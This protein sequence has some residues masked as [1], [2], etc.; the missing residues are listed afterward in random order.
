M[1]GRDSGYQNGDSE[2]W[3]EGERW[4][5]SGSGGTTGARSTLPSRDVR[6][7]E[8]FNEPPPPRNDRWKEPEPREDRQHSRWPSD[9]VRRTSNRRDEVC[10]AYHV[11]T[12]IVYDLSM[13]GYDL[14]M[15]RLASVRWNIVYVFKLWWKLEVLS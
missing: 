1:T 8:D 14:S 3:T 5:G 4:G 10:D 7:D 9:D 6:R 11:V 15:L 13:I 2:R 12:F